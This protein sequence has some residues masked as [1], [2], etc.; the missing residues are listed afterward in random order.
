MASVDQSRGLMS[1]SHTRYEG[2]GLKVNINRPTSSLKLFPILSGA[3]VSPVS[4]QIMINEK[5][6]SKASS[7]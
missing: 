4:Y 2:S 6:V 1:V 7:P 5:L 3:E